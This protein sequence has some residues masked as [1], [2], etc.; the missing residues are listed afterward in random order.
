MRVLHGDDEGREFVFSRAALAALPGA[1]EG[2]TTK[3]KKVL[4]AGVSMGVGKNGS[5]TAVVRW[6]G[7]GESTLPF[8][9]LKRH[10]KSFAN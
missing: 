3:L 6:E 7:G 4:L 1:P 2:A 9:E 10:A 5:P 8:E